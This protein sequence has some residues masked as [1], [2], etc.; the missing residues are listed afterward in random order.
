M[1]VSVTV[2]LICKVHNLSHLADVVIVLFLNLCDSKVL[3]IVTQWKF[4]SSFALSL[5]STATGQ[6]AWN[7]HNDHMMIS[8]IIETGMLVKHSPHRLTLLVTYK[9]WGCYCKGYKNQ[10]TIKTVCGMTTSEAARR[11]WLPSI[12]TSPNGCWS[13]EVLSSLFHQICLSMTVQ[14]TVLGCW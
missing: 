13:R 12:V 7:I 9:S 10:S 14:V 8:Y 11:V 4:G 2:N 1:A 5:D 6:C 3:F